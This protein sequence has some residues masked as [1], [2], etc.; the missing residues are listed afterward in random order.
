MATRTRLDWAR[1]VVQAIGAGIA[2]VVV[3]DLYLY[4]SSVLPAHGTQ[5]QMWQWIASVAIG[6]IA[7]T[8]PSYAW[9]GALVDLVVG[10]AWA[11][12]YAYFAQQQPFVNA[13]WLISGLMYGLIVYIFMQVLLLGAHA[14][15]WPPT[16]AQ[17]VNQ[18]I[19]R[20]LFFGVPVAYTVARLSR[21]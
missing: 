19:A 4:V 3:L 20:M 13:S 5:E 12:G 10:T 21:A 18:I 14:F 9:L 6:P 16:P 2:G 1:I 17:F 15:V 8:N 11:G 7:L